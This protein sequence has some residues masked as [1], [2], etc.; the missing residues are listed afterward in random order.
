MNA[1]G[2]PTAT[3]DGISPGSSGVLVA[4]RS[5]A[6]D[7]LHTLQGIQPDEL[8]VVI[9]GHG[10]DPGTSGCQ[11][12]SFPALTG[13]PPSRILVA[14]CLHNL[15]GK[16]VTCKHTAQANIE[17]NENCCCQFTVHREDFEPETWQ[18]LVQAPVRVINDTFVQGGHPRPFHSPWGRTYLS[19]GR[20]STPALADCVSF[21]AR[22][23][24]SEVEQTLR[25]S[26]HNF[27][28]TVPKTWSRQ[29]HPDFAIVWL[30]SNRADALRAS[31]QLPEQ[32][33]LARN[34]DK[35]GVCIAAGAFSKAY[36]QLHPGQDVPKRMA[37]SELYR[38]GP[39]PPEVGPRDV[40]T[41]T[42]KIGWETR[43]IKALG[44]SHWLLGSQTGPAS[45]CL[46]FNNQSILIVPVSNRT[47]SQSF[48]QSGAIPKTLAP[49]STP[50]ADEDPW[51]HTDP[52]KSYRKAQASA[53]S[54]AKSAP[55]QPPARFLQGPTETRFQ[56]QESRIH[57]IEQGLADLKSCSEKRHQEMVAARQEDSKMHSNAVTELR[58]QMHSLSSDFAAQLR[59]SVEAFK[60]R[61]VSNS[62]K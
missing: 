53:A 44:A 50:A 6:Q 24:Q 52:W 22:I 58:G 39:F 25:L 5:Q 19:K 8:A 3:L 12:L 11:P 13:N 26:G 54:A 37:V 10:C 16:R 28:Y 7:L 43:V 55:L 51:T 57:A 61:K 29:P 21:H 31:L 27:V 36:N 35:Y 42:A 46:A 45:G 41:W 40:A 9:L 32:R 49:T 17:V 1:D 4:D 20:P 14:G 33:G 62:S 48:V 34:R 30:A 59:T 38:A 15:G 2:T 47:T 56:E 60:E 18:Q 23:E